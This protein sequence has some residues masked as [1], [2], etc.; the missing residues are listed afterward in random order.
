VD[1]SIGSDEV[2]RY[3]ADGF[4]VATS[5]G[6]TAYSLSAGGPVVEPELDVMVLTPVCPHSLRWRPIVVGPQRVVTMRLVEGGA[7]L[8]ADG[9]PVALLPD[10]ATVSVRRHHERLRLVRLRGD[11][12]LMRFKSRF[13]PGSYR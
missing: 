8:S 11:D 2:A 6:S 12:F 10:G 7:A 1:L 13:D 4:I 3:T 9:Q 5:T